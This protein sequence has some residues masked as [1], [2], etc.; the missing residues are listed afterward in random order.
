MGIR[1][2]DGN[3][4]SNMSAEDTKTERARGGPKWRGLGLYF[5]LL[6]VQTAGVAILLAY[7]VPLYRLMA[8]D[9]ARYKPDLKPWWTI[10][11]IL[12]IQ[13]AYWFRVRLQPPLP[14]TGHIV[15]GHIVSFV[16]RISFVA[17][18]ASF[19]VM[20]LNRFPELRNINYSPLR[21]LVILVMFFSIFCWTLELERLA[22]ALHESTHENSQTH[23]D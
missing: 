5:F 12:L 8:L 20:F 18:T 11:G 7:A 17:V 19:T 2:Q 6:S 9:F 1:V 15:L 21:A 3:T 23:R 22:K 14:R 16:A 10:A 13:V 4:G